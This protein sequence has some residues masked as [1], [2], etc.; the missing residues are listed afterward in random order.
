MV[1]TDMVG[2]GDNFV[3]TRDNMP[4]LKEQLQQAIEADDRL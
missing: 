1:G 4:K 2:A 3:L